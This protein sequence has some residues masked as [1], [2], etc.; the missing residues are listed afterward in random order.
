MDAE[1]ERLEVEPVGAHD[2]DLAVDDTP[3]G[4][5]GR[6]G[7]EKLREVPVHRLL[8]AAL[9]QDLLA[10]TEYERAEAVPLGLE[11]PPVAVRQAV[12][13]GR[14]HRRERRREGQAHGLIV[15]RSPRRMAED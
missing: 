6:E 14:E 8:V 10:V 5:R 11:L 4:Q 1:Q 3:M 12:G 9:E 15:T 2:D 13:G 7:C